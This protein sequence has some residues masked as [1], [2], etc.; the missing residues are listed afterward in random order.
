MPLGAIF[1]S[2]YRKPGNTGLKVG[3]GL[4]AQ[5]GASG[6]VK[7]RHL[8]DRADN[9][10]SLLR[11]A[12]RHHHVVEDLHQNA[13]SVR[14]C[15]GARQ[16]R[17]PRKAPRKVCVS[18]R[19]AVAQR[20]ARHQTAGNYHLNLNRH[21]QQQQCRHQQNARDVACCIDGMGT[22]IVQNGTHKKANHA[23]AEDK[24]LIITTSFGDTNSAMRTSKRYS[25]AKNVKENS[26][27]HIISRMPRRRYAV[28]SPMPLM[29]NPRPLNCLEFHFNKEPISISKPNSKCC[30]FDP[31]RSHH[32]AIFSRMDQKGH[33]RPLARQ[34]VSPTTAHLSTSPMSAT[35][36]LP[37]A[38]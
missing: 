17:R 31:S 30:K 10:S 13:H 11:N 34:G 14:K 25:H 22:V 9:Q 16:P 23:R 1:Q 27:R 37:L 7:Q 38:A 36:W 4:V 19:P 28:V 33:A 6:T 3:I 35:E 26:A 32:A 2:I 18:S 20:A 5:L 15:G 8:R 24:A 21:N 29:V 12:G